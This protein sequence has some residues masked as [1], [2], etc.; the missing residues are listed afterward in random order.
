MAVVPSWIEAHCVVPD[1]FRLGRPFALYDYQLRYVAH[2]Y[3]VR[4]NAR[5]V[6]ANPILAPAFAHRRGLLVG[7]Q[8]L[9]KNPLIACQVCVEGVGPALF[10]GWAG[11]DDGYACAEHGCGCGW[12]YPYDPGE[13]MGMR[14]PTPL[15]QITA[16]SED[17]TEN[18]YDA[19][20]PMIEKGPL[21][22]LIPKTGEEFIRLPGDGRIDTVTSSNQSR[23]GQRTTFVPQDEVGLWT[24]QTKMVKLAD[25]QYRNLAGMGGRS[26]L[27]TNPW[28]P[29]EHS[30]AQQQYESGATDI[31]RQFDQPPAG[32]SYA[33]KAD[34]LR[35]HRAVYPAD[36]WRENG[37][38]VDL[39]AIESE[40]ADL[41]TRDLPQAAR[42]YGNQ[43]ISGAGVAVEAS[44][45]A[46]LQKPREVPAKTLIGIGID[47]S[48]SR[49]AT[50]MRAC[51]AD[52]YGFTL[53]KWIRPAGAPRNWRVPRV[54][55]HATLAWAMDYYRVGRVFVDPPRWW[56]EI[57][58][59]I[60]LY[61]EELV[62]HFDTNQ[63]SRFAPEC[64]RWLTA[65]GHRVHEHDDD[66]DA[67]AHVLAMHRRKVRINAPD[68]DERTMYVFVKGDDRRQI[69]GGIADVLA[70]AAAM[71][72]PEP[73]EIDRTPR[74]W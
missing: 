44:L 60:E 56:Q 25:T 18:T 8:K 67:N 47:G 11:R 49:D 24:A 48:V 30:V 19:L 45:W 21:A 7:P 68:D 73:V 2:F 14:W 36:T 37:G 54:E 57:D 53:D 38:H 65:V 29:S 58:E 46:D 40:G 72:M 22:D 51:T 41:A 5:W 63:A 66:E 43:L 4:G 55:V 71:T 31:Y 3:L 34:R 32:L 1:G 39:D 62:L 28:D 42:F 33:R 52:G 13:P 16:F 74:I 12:E 17:A 50:F 6:P 20:R 35:I 26:S 23:L 61:G 9:G 64:D 27:T 69:D 70:F 59:W 15:I 10:A